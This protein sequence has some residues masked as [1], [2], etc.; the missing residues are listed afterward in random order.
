MHR[1]HCILSTI[2]ATAAIYYHAVIQSYIQ[3]LFSELIYQKQQNKML[4]VI[5]VTVMYVLYTYHTYKLDV[6][7]EIQSPS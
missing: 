5:L 7:E 1:W 4:L 3:K 6:K 2:N